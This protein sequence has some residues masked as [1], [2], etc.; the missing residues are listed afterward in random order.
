LIAHFEH[1]LNEAAEQADPEHLTRLA[2]T[3]YI[4]KTGEFENIWWRVEN[5]VNEIKD[6]LDIYNVVNI[7]RAFSRSQNNRMCGTN[8]TFI[9]L[10]PIVL[11]HLDKVSDRDA[12]HLMY[13]YSVREVGNPELYA[14]FDKRLETMIGRLDYPSL[15]NAIY[16]ML[17]REIARPE[18]WKQVIEATL[19]QDEVLPLIYYRPFKA[20]K[21][22]MER[23]FPDWDLSNFQD[24]FFNAE[25]CF[26]VMLLDNNY[27]KDQAYVDF[28]VFLNGHCL[29]FPT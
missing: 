5:R 9:N 19:N 23:K 29:V 8:K 21:L 4:L 17:F 25:N 15:F 27:E 6:Q 12:S 10:E 11:K 1:D 16:Y 13:S 26:N 22:F 7:T 18:L 24:K 28:K 20:A 3:M 14:A 2:Q